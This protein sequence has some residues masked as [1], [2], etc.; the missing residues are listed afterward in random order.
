MDVKF[1]VGDE[2]ECI[3]ECTCPNLGCAISFKHEPLGKIFT[4]VDIELNG[5]YLILETSYGDF[6]NPAKKFK[7]AEKDNTDLSDWV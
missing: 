5:K 4:V 7:L 3:E 2:V 1:E 6:T